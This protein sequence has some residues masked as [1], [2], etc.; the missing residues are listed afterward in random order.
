LAEADGAINLLGQTPGISD[1]CF[2]AVIITTAAVI[3][4]IN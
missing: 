2:A 4:L 3:K 1:V